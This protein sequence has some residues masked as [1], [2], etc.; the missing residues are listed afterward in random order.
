[1]AYISARNLT[2]DF[3]VYGAASRSLKNVVL[4][5]A[6]GGSLAKDIKERV[7]VRALDNLTFEINEGD[8]VGILG[9]NG[10]GKSTLLRVLAGGYEPVSGELEISGTVAS[11]LS[12][13]LG[14]DGEATGYENIKICCA[15][16]GLSTREIENLMPSIAEFTELGE[17]LSMPLRTYSSGMSMRIPFA[18][19]TAVRTDI[20]L[21]DEWLSVGDEAFSHKAQQRLHEMLDSAKILVLASHNRALL[22]SSCNRI[23]HLEHG[24][25]AQVEIL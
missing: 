12:I 24:N 5:S 20:V 17:Y 9:H 16:T 18:V 10:S 13:T 3:P 8:R 6:T 2:V 15:L 1:M 19:A 21:M 25:L 4:H 23:F 11:M 7:V 22:E 14:I